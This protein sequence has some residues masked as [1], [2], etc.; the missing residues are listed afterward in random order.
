[1]PSRPVGVAD[2]PSATTVA[3]VNGVEVPILDLNAALTADPGASGATLAIN[4]WNVRWPA[5]GSFKLRIEKEV[6][7]VT[8]GHT[9]TSLTV[10]RAQDGTTGVAHASSTPVYQVGLLQRV[11]PVDERI[12]SYKGRSNTFKT[13]GRAAVSQKI[14]AIHNATGSA[15]MVAVNRVRI[16]LLSTVAKA[17]TVI[18]PV[19]RLHRFTAIPTNGTALTKTPLDNALTSNASVTVWGDASAD[20]TGSATTL[21]VT[22]P[23]NSILDQVFGPRIISAAGYEMV[24]TAE[25]F[26]GEPDVILGPLEG[27]VVFLDQAVVTTGNPATDW[28]ISMI[29]WTEYTVA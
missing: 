18:P 13:P 5:S 6:V 15:V 16:D 26:V 10:T 21:T 24:D 8:A 14:A 7:L 12:I 3:E 29:D 22:V 11:S 28:W 17:V 20:G 19:I 23:A 4:A 1:M 9:T 25:F 2:A 27:L